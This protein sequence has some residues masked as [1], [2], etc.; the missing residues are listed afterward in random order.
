MRSSVLDAKLLTQMDCP[1]R[2]THVVKRVHV[3]GFPV[4]IVVIGANKGMRG[5]GIER[6]NPPPHYTVQTLI[7]RVTN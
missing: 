3:G 7:G 1:T 5:E 4:G 6:E 2:K